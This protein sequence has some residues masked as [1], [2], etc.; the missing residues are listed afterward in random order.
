MVYITSITAL[1][2]RSLSATPSPQNDYVS[3]LANSTMAAAPPPPTPGESTGQ[4]ID[5]IFND[6]NSTSGNETDSLSSTLSYQGNIPINATAL[7]GPGQQTEKREYKEEHGFHESIWTND[8]EQITYNISVDFSRCSTGIRYSTNVGV[9]TFTNGTTRNETTLHDMAA[10]LYTLRHSTSTPNT[11]FANHIAVVAQLALNELNQLLK[12]YLICPVWTPGVTPP[13]VVP[14]AEVTQEIIHVELRKLLANRYSY[15]T[16]VVISAVAGGG[17]GASLAAGLDYGFKGNVTA[18][19]TIQTAAVVAVTI[20]IAGIL[21]HM[22]EVGH[23]DAA[24]PIA[25]GVV[26]NARQLVPAGREALTQSTFVSNAR[27]LAGTIRRVA[28][29]QRDLAEAQQHAVEMMENAG[30]EVPEDL[31]HAV[32][33]NVAGTTSGSAAIPNVSVMAN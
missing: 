18:Q 12:D 26:N 10:D 16:S 6:S 15:W 14:I 33:A 32:E 7:S 13:T 23:L 8:T 11:R 25:Q 17:A 22:H 27:T 1:L 30:V 29:H 3:G 4:W 9:Y 21:N 24:Q 20:L 5:Q 31:A 19:N 2:P 28:S